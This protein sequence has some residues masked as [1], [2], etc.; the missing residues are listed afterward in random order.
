MH[1]H[2]SRDEAVALYKK[3]TIAISYTYNGVKTIEF[4]STDMNTDIHVQVNTYK[5]GRVEAFA[6]PLSN[7]VDTI[8]DDIMIDTDYMNVIK[9]I[10]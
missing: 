3:A 4:K 8:F 7:L 5:T 6:Q 10:G 1:T 9:L 2:I